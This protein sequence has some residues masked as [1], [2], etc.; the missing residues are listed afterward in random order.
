[1]QNFYDELVNEY[2]LELDF[3]AAA[4]MLK[5]PHPDGDG[6][7]ASVLGLEKQ[8]RIYNTAHMP[9]Q[10]KRWWLNSEIVEQITS[11]YWTA[12]NAIDS[13]FMVDGMSHTKTD[14]F[15][16][17]SEITDKLPEI[18]VCVGKAV[19]AIQSAYEEAR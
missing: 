4:V 16:P 17:F 14:L 3:K 7:G 5:V 8:G 19:S 13:R 18:K 11:E 12:L 2:G 1:M 6:L 9:N 15:I 10:L